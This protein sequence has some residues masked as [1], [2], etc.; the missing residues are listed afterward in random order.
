PARMV[1]QCPV[2]VKLPPTGGEGAKIMSYMARLDN[3]PSDKWFGYVNGREHYGSEMA[4]YNE[5]GD[6]ID[7]FSIDY[8]SDEHDD[9]DIPAEYQC[10]NLLGYGPGVQLVHDALRDRG[11]TPISDPWESITDESELI[12][13]RSTQ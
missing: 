1:V 6:E 10:P 12:Y 9:A 8:Y 2:G 7:L 5:Y 13:V 4:I 3:A 11:W